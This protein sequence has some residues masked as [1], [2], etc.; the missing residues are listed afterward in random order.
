MTDQASG[1]VAG[2]ASMRS[3][4]PRDNILLFA[5]CILAI[6]VFMAVFAPLIV[7]YPPEQMSFA[8]TSQA[9]SWAHPFGTDR[10]GRDMLS[11]TI[12]G[13]QLTLAFGFGSVAICFLIGLP[14]G[15]I[16]AYYG[17]IVDQII[18]RIMDILM[19]FPTL[20][21]GLLILTI[22]GPDLFNLIVAVGIVYCPRTTRVV[23]AAALSLTHATFIEAAKARAEPSFYIVV[24]ELLPCAWGAIIVELCIRLGYSI[25]LG[26]SFNYLGLGV[27]PPAADWGLL[28]YEARVQ[29]FTAPWTVIFPI[30]F[31]ISLVAS[32][33]LVGDSIDERLK[34]GAVE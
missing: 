7:P 5:A 19:S 2:L 34:E 32:L 14:A 6:H 16:S 11:R 21:L 1:P 22:A 12:M 33:N 24:R 29:M 18:M 20:L 13:G 15:L 10:Y 23:R 4:L 25:L 26:A 3:F 30:L 27:Q 31:I 9:P 8:E 17:G 28:V